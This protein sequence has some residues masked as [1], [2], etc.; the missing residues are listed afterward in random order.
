MVTEARIGHGPQAQSVGKRKLILR[1]GLVHQTL[2]KQDTNTQPRNGPHHDQ[3]FHLSNYHTCPLS[4]LS[5]SNPDAV[6]S[7]EKKLPTEGFSQGWENLNQVDLIIKLPR[8]PKHWIG[9]NFP[10]S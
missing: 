5:V 9:Y 4:F 3:S 1:K 7:K 2:E 6:G 10:M 8:L